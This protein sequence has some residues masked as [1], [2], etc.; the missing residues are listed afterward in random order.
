[1]QTHEPAPARTL[2][3]RGGGVK[4]LFK[5]IEGTEVPDD[6]LAKGTILQGT[7]GSTFG[8]RLGQ[9]LPEQG[10]VNVTYNATMK[11][12]SATCGQ[13][14]IEPDKTRVMIRG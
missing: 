3:T 14:E 8:A 9:V 12:G 5:G 4:L 13:H 2:D 1:M 7:A 6:G 10:V 11:K